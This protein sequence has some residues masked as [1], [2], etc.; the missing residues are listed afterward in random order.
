MTSLV[1]RTLARLLISLLLMF[2]IFLLLRGHQSPGGGFVAGLVAAAA[3]VL[4]SMA[5]DIP[6]A[7][8]FL[9]VD[10]ALLIWIGLLIAMLSGVPG[11]LAGG[12]FLTGH[13]WE[14]APPGVSGSLT[15]GTPLIFDV[16]VFLV[17]LGVAVTLALSMAEE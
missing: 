17:V 9:R 8:R 1:L 7:R 15:I 6:S 4:F 3:V 5:Y 10:P 16:G 14:I 2:A 12:S 13:W 11:L